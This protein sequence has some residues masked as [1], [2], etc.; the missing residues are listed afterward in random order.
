M[1]ETVESVANLTKDEKY[2]KFLITFI[3]EKNS[4]IKTEQENKINKK[5]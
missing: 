1:I 2:D 4:R 3:R 5:I